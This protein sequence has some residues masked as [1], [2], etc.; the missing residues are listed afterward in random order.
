MSMVVSLFTGIISST[1]NTI[2]EC[3]NK[4]DMANG[5]L[6]RIIMVVVLPIFCILALLSAGFLDLFFSAIMLVIPSVLERQSSNKFF[7]DSRLLEMLALGGA[8]RA[9]FLGIISPSLVLNWDQSGW[10]QFR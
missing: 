10:A 9:L 1:R 7:G 6:A 8:I 5:I 2:R 4:N 3:V